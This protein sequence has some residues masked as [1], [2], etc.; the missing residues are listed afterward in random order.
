M[1]A[2][3]GGEMGSWISP[4]GLVLGLG[5]GLGGALTALWKE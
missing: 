4:L 3:H 5:A 1:Q 2:V